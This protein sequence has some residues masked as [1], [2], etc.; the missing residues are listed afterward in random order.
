MQQRPNNRSQVVYTDDHHT[1]AV[2]N[3]SQNLTQATG[4]PVPA[5]QVIPPAEQHPVADLSSY[6]LGAGGQTDVDQDGIPDSVDPNIGPSDVDNFVQG[7]QGKPRHAKAVTFL[8]EKMKWLKKKT[9]KEV[10]LKQ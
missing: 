2:N 7:I 4:Q 10:T 1:Q 9:G 3:I 8:S 6:G 5:T